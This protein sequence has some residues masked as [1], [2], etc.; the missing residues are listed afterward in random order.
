MDDVSTQGRRQSDLGLQGRRVLV[1]GAT[2]A[3]G[4]A[5]V[6]A[7]TAAGAEVHALVR[8]NVVVPGATAT[9]PGELT[10]G[11]SLAAAVEGMYG[12]VHLAALL[13]ITDPPAELEVQ[14][15]RVNDDGTARLVDA[16]LR[17]GVARFV[18][19]STIAVYGPTSPGAAPWNEAATC[20]PD[21]AYARTKLAGEAHVRAAR[22]GDGRPVGVVLRL[23]AVYGADVKGNYRRLLDALSR[24]RYVHVGP[25]RNRRSL[26][27]E[28][29]VAAAIT[30]A[31]SH[32][33]AAG[34]TFNV[35]DGQ[36]HEMREIVAAMC[37]AVGK[38]VPRVRIPV[39][40]AR[41]MVG[42]MELVA[43]TAHRR[44]PMTAATLD[45]LLEDVAVS[46]DRIAM[47]L[48]FTPQF[49]L[50]SGWRE[51]VSRMQHATALSPVE[52]S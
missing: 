5:V 17:A 7:L 47:A 31:L 20:H 46:G 24:G 45:K 8:R 14:Y 12:V 44:A 51:V 15:R 37:A 35:T 38:R 48:G 28:A 41:T 29:D 3:L 30:L 6:A 26:V 34:Q 1:T 43:R 16:S 27:H 22:G 9:H 10:D 33:A 11:A 13:H 49:D 36:L 50:E 42:T 40:I 52:L 19:A 18:Y 21:S 2:G 23:G 4:P 32:T 39:P 25:G